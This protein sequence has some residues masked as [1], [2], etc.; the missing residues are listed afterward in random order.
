M[1]L[2]IAANSNAQHE[3]G[4]L[5]RAIDASAAIVHS[6]RVQSL[7]DDAE[8]DMAILRAVARGDR[9]ALGRL[10][11]RYASALL[12]LGVRIIGNRREIEDIVHDVFLEAWR[13]AGDYD[14]ARGSV[15]TWLVVRMRSRCLD[16]LRSHAYARTEPWSPDEPSAPAEETTDSA[17]RA[18][19]GA[20]VLSVLH[21]LPENQRAVLE[22]GYFRGLS[23][24]E[25]AHE[26][27]IPLGTVKSRV[28][29]AMLKL[30]RDLGGSE[31]GNAA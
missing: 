22:L 30:R 20:R 9:D 25:I 5:F 4:D 27:D 17:E 12:G 15:K 26:L 19:D 11:D 13:S 8:H 10:Y 6:P 28:A 29:A 16:R 2:W 1:A 7:A 21:A 14:P 24:Q 3:V 31:G 18:I 23:F